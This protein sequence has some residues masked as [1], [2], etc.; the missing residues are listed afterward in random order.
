MNNKV[1]RRTF[2]LSSATAA[3]TGCATT[4]KPT[5]KSLGYQS[6]NEKLN[7]A[8]IGVGGKGSSDIDGCDSE[9]IVALCDVDWE[10]AGRTFKRYP[11]AKR[12]RDFRVMLEREKNIDALT[13]STADHMHAFAAMRAMELGK[14]IYVQKPLTHSVYEARVLTEAARKYGVATQMGNQGH[15]GDELRV[16]CEMI[17][18]GVIGPVREVHCWTNRPIWPQ[19]IP[20]PLPPEPVPDH[21]DWNLWLGPAPWR[22][23]NSGYAPFKWRGWFDFGTGALGDMGCHVLDSTNFALLLDY[24]SSVECIS[25]QGKNEQTYP[26]KSIIRYEFPARPSMPPVTVYWYD[27]GNKPKVPEE[28]ENEVE[29]ET[30]GS[31]F[32]GEKG[33]ITSGSYAR[34]MKVLPE[35]LA[36]DPQPLIPRSPGHYRDW[37]QAI[38]GGVP[39]CS[40]FNYAGPFTEWVLLGNIAL[41]AEGKLMWDG[42]RM[43]FTN[44]SDANQYIKRE[45][46]AGW[47]L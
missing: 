17:W 21:I 6:P 26:E 2:L 10:R 41:R 47:R 13:I 12:Y 42:P 43:R 24:P 29:L 34:K 44:N 28:F 27:G 8:G 40:N 3:I 19:G 20:E 16:F 33:I 35:S 14:H 15:S 30:S 18:A 9:N 7:V 22:P 4:R 1:N 38:K 46:R 11:A 36:F 39:P 32:I 37:I 45:Y 5:L 23:Y 25:Q 31:I